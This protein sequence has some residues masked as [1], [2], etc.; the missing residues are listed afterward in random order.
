MDPIW[1]LWDQGELLSMSSVYI[2][3]GVV[4]LLRKGCFRLCRP[5]G[6]QC[7]HSFA[8][9]VWKP[10]QTKW[11]WNVWL[12][13]SKDLLTKAVGKNGSGTQ[14]VI[15]ELL[16]QRP[17]NYLLEVSAMESNR[18][19]HG[20]P[21]DANHFGFPMQSE[22][23]GCLVIMVIVSKPHQKGAPCWVLHSGLGRLSMASGWQGPTVVMWAFPNPTAI[24]DKHR[25]E[26]LVC[27]LLLHPPQRQHL[28]D[29]IPLT[30]WLFLFCTLFQSLS[31]L[32][33]T[34]CIISQ[35]DVQSLVPYLSIGS[36]E[37]ELPGDS[38]V[39]WEL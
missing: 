32:T 31:T 36:Q 39:R 24:G 16:R 5:H 12:C 38:A 1:T 29:T 17:R 35:W 28:E 3:N 15:H 26:S 22:V 2:P 27:I 14:A 34:L 6:L 37:D 11:R 19:N 4:S 13:S 25:M 8:T 33:L 7:T 18:K 10:T 30:S 23:N 21:L 20:S 9:M